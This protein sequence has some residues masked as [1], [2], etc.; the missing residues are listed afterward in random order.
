MEKEKEYYKNTVET[1]NGKV[2]FL[3]EHML[4]GETE[5]S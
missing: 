3:M 5:S 4:N 1:L 2:D